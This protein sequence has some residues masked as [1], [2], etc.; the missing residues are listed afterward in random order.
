[1]DKLGRKPEKGYLK[2]IF[3]NPFNY[4]IMSKMDG[5]SQQGGYGNFNKL[6]DIEE[7]QK[8]LRER[9]LAFGDSFIKNKDETNKELGKIKDELKS[10]KSEVE[11]IK[12][13]AEH[14]LEEFGNVARK[15]E[16]ASLQR[17]IK[18]FDPLKN[19]REEDVKRII[20]EESGKVNK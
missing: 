9:I 2:G 14:L 19:L 10:L 3:L 6:S 17:I 11:K 15:E 1:M 20:R 18:I 4:F 5:E 13:I 8:I 12:E 16:L 7:K